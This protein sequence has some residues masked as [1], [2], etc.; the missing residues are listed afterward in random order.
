VLKIKSLLKAAPLLLAIHSPSY[1]SVVKVDV[2]ADLSSAFFYCNEKNPC[3]LNESYLLPKSILISAGDTVD[4]RVSFARGQ[5]LEMTNKGGTD[6]FIG[7]LTQDVKL[8]EPNTSTGYISD[9]SMTLLDSSGRS[10][11]NLYD[12]WFYFGRAAIGGQFVGS[13]IPYGASIKFSSY[14]TTFKVESLEGGSQYYDAPNVVFHELNLGTVRLV[15]ADIP[16]P[17]TSILG[18]IG[19]FGVIASLRRRRRK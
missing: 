17:S 13:Y 19:L 18:A 14:R 1:A 3:G 15:Q 16:E 12:P 5:A 2:T 8:S 10:V 4:M 7:W 9:F 6:V 11:L